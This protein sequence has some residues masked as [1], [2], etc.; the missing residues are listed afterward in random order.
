MRQ[1]RLATLR[2]SEE[3][4]TVATGTTSTKYCDSGIIVAATI[5]TATN[6][7]VI[8][9]GS[10]DGQILRLIGIDN[11]LRAR[12]AKMLLAEVCPATGASWHS[13]RSNVSCLVENLKIGAFTGSEMEKEGMYKRSAHFWA[14]DLTPFGTVVD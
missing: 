14:L 8:P 7:P 6:R 12:P 11:Y 3:M 13:I 2:L 9:V 10:A 5:V 1:T 4:K